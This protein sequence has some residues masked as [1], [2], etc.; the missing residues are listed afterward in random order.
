[1]G[2]LKCPLLTRSGH[3]NPIVGSLQQFAA[4]EPSTDRAMTTKVYFLLEMIYW[5]RSA[6]DYPS[7]RC[8]LIAY[9]SAREQRWR[10]TS[11]AK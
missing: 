10:T 2:F 8:R 3:A 6:E 9:M 1:M 7:R 4:W 5:Q 11:M